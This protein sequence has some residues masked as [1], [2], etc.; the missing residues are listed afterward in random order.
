MGGMEMKKSEIRRA[1]EKINWA[2]ICV[3]S[4]IELEYSKDTLQDETLQKHLIKDGDI[5]EEA[6]KLVMDLC[7]YMQ[8]VGEIDLSEDLQIIHDEAVKIDCGVYG[9]I[10]EYALTEELQPLFSRIFLNV[11]HIWVEIQH[12]W[13]FK[14]CKEKQTP[15]LPKELDNELFK[16]I[17]NRG[18]KAGIIILEAGKYKWKKSKELLA[19]FAIRVTE[20]LN[21][22]KRYN[23]MA[24]YKPFE[25]LF[26]EDNLRGCPFDW[27]DRTGEDHKNFKP[28]GWEEIEA[29]LNENVK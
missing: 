2:F 9:R 20:L 21:L 11:S 4:I 29:L 15:S 3:M 25:I 13:E 12:Y 16:Q 5:M 7:D 8:D 17:L 26:E 6:F 23:A 10:P 14:E 18:I 24:N 19:Y 27:E 28:N 22:K 1:L